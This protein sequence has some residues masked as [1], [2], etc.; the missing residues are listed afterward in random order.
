MG[1]VSQHAF[2]VRDVIIRVT[3]TDPLVSM[4]L[5]LMALFALLLSLALVGWYRT[6][7]RRRTV[8]AS[9]AQDRRA[10]I[11]SLR[12]QQYELQAARARYAEIQE[13]LVR[14]QDALA[15]G[16]ARIQE[17]TELAGHL[18][19]H[20]RDLQAQVAS[21]E[22]E[23]SARDTVIT[24]L[25]AQVDTERRCVDELQANLGETEHMLSER[26]AALAQSAGELIEMSNRLDELNA[27][28]A[29]SESAARE[30]E[31]RIAELKA[32][33]AEHSSRADLLAARLATTETTL[34]DR[35][36]VINRIGMQLADISSRADRVSAQLIEAERGAAEREVTLVRLRAQLED[37]CTQLEAANIR[38]VEIEKQVVDDLWVV[39]GVGPVYLRKL[40]AAGI[41]RYQ[42]LARA[43]PEQ[44]HA[45]LQIPEWRKPNYAGW[46]EQA[47]QLNT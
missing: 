5:V 37:L 40:R 30:R 25:Q 24:Q 20:S 41:R 31:I 16:Q 42:D 18:E 36:A 17:L 44:L 33:L 13:H 4:A 3:M 14:A 28:L 9:F 39:K 27:R 47:K 8:L 21:A 46:I 26:E 45:I 19:S 22:R 11:R 29:E 10:M 35:D 2:T 23:S 32:Q 43:S 1:Y 7:W 6:E 12:L 38:V 34:G 15:N